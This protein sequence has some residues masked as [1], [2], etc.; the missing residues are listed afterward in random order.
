MLRAESLQERGDLHQH[1]QWVLLS[2]GVG[3]NILIFSNNFLYSVLT[4]GRVQPVRKMLTSVHSLLVFQILAVRTEQ[5]ARTCQ[6]HTAA[7]VLQGTMEC[8][9]GRELTAAV[10]EHLRFEKAT[11][12]NIDDDDDVVGAMRAWSVC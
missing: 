5:P 6:E 10:V 7:T 4:T 11:L 2:G 8:T 12:E 9:A 3:D 1:L